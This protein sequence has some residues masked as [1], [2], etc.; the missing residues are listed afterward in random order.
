MGEAVNAETLRNYLRFSLST[1][2][3]SPYWSQPERDAV[4]GFTELMC[5]HFGIEK[6]LPAPTPKEKQHDD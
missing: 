4:E 1:V 2:R 5:D 3:R 6:P